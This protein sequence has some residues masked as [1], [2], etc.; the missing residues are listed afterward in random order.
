MLGQEITYL[1]GDVRNLG[2]RTIRALELTLEY[3]DINGEKIHQETL[4]TIGS[5][6]SPSPLGPGEARHFQ[7]AF[8]ARPP[9]WNQRPPVVRIR[10]LLLQ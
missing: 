10:G 3:Q 1:D 4:R 9:G 8:E 2:G 5:R 7:H 6:I